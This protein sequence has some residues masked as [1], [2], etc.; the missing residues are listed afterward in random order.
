MSQ[1]SVRLEV[2]INMSGFSTVVT[3]SVV[4]RSNIDRRYFLDHAEETRYMYMYI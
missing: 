4:L 1:Y 3:R 2:I